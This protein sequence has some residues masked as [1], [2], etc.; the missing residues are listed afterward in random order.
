MR[1][2]DLI[3]V[4]FDNLNN[5]EKYVKFKIQYYRYNMYYAHIMFEI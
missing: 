5:N 1:G 4:H 2:D 3:I